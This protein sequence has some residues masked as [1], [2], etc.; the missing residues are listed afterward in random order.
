MKNDSH[1]IGGTQQSHR[2]CI[3]QYSILFIAL[4][5]WWMV[6]A[7]SK[8]LIFIWRRLRRF[9]FV[10][11]NCYLWL[12]FCRPDDARHTSTPRIDSRRS[13]LPSTNFS[14]SYKFI[15]FT[16]RNKTCT[17]YLYAWDDPNARAAVSICLCDSRRFIDECRWRRYSHMGKNRVM[18][19]LLFSRNF[20]L[21][22]PRW[23]RGGRMAR[24]HNGHCEYTISMFS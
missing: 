24:C 12:R 11:V 1:F 3:R 2:K 4:M 19:L 22:V 20:V 15:Y 6:K 16:F 7:A 13:M 5:Q 23:G 14:F 10:C 9:L 17:R 18:N 21:V 8:K